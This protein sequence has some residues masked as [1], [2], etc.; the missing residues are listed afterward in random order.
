ME[1]TDAHCHIFAAPRNDAIRAQVCNATN[2]SDW[3][4]IV[5]IADERTRACIGIH[6]WHIHTATDG[7]DDRMRKILG[8]NPHIM[9]GEIGIDKHHPNIETQMEFFTRQ[10]EIA[11]EFDRP[12]HLHVV[13]AWDK[14]LH[15]LKANDKSPLPPIIAHGFNGNT[16]I[17]VRVAAESNIYFSYKIQ[18]GR[19]IGEIETAPLDKI[20]AESDCDA[21]DKQFEILQNTTREIAKILGRPENEINEQINKNFQRAMNYV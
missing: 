7:W 15:I 10:M 17:L 1:Y 12:M 4:K 16:N 20:L 13:G 19:I 2:E 14:I 21:P 6:P 3:E 18:N 9:V 8:A 5:A 11:I